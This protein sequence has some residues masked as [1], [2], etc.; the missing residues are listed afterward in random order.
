M[1]K[2]NPAKPESKKGLVSFRFSS[3]NG[4]I[5]APCR[6]SRETFSA[7]EPNQTVEEYATFLK[8]LISADDKALHEIDLTLGKSVGSVDGLLGTW[9]P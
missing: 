9:L 4:N 2:A 3:S 1:E 5:C 6:V 7:M 8:Y